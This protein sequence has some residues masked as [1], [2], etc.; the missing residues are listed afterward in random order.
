MNEPQEIK[1]SVSEAAKFLGVST[2]TIRRAI[3]ENK[4]QYI[5]VQGRYKITLPSLLQFAKDTTTVHNKL[6]TH[7]FG[8][9][10]AS[11]SIRPEV[12]PEET[13]EPL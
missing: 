3:T 6:M 12:K 13:K 11:W 8:R 9:Y 7:G 5:V 10:V 2:R 4:V 1:L